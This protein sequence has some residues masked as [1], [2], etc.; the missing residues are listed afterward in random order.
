MTTLSA[1]AKINLTLEVLG[2]R[3]DGYHDIASVMQTI[4]LA[5]TL[6][7]EKD[8]QVRLLCESPGLAS[9][10]N[11]VL[12]AAMLLQEAGKCR[13]GVKMRL[14]KAIPIAAGLGGGSSDAAA[15]LLG[16]NEF[17]KLNLPL[18]QLIPLASEL[19]SDVPFFLMGGTALVKG[20]GEWVTPL[21]AL[22][23]AW[24]V[25]LKPSIDI[26]SKTARLYAALEEADFTAGEWTERLVALLHQGIFPDASFLFNV[27][28]RAAFAFYPGLF[29][30]RQ[31]FLDAGA[32]TVHLAGAG[33]TLFVLVEDRSRGEELHQRLCGHGL[34][35]YLVQTIGAVSALDSQGR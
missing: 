33:P 13:Q 6:S 5:D 17:W 16:L 29:D 8:D 19:G 35:A 21:P 11:L 27:F 4:D 3:A 20:R 32:A 31:R 22:P 18:Q 30:Y 10:D 12:R 9:P 14:Q 25:L 2:R 24:V 7:F 15:T 28:Q 34:E 1:Y 23:H 26:P